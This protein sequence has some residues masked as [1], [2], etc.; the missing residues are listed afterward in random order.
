MGKLSKKDFEDV[1][2]EWKK[3]RELVGIILRKGGSKEDY[4]KA[5]NMVRFKRR[6]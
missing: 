6:N 3:G 5:Y 1:L 4:K 2:R